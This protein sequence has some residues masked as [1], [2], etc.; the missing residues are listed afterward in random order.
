MKFLLKVYFKINLNLKQ[1]TVKQ[2]FV[3]KY[4]LNYEENE[5]EKI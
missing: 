3:K 4:K 2:K 5:D 1:H